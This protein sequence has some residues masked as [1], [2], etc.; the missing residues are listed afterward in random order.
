MPWVPGSITAVRIQ[1]DLG[2]EGLESSLG[3]QGFTVYETPSIVRSGYT[4]FD[5]AVSHG[6]S[7]LGRFRE[8]YSDKISSGPVGH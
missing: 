5:M 6:H 7:V 1:W 4:Q 2:D 3:E 8:T